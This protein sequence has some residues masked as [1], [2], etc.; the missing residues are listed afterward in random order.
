MVST[1][2]RIRV[3]GLEW[4]DRL[5]GVAMLWVVLNHIVEIVAGGNFAGAPTGDWP[6][7]SVRIAQWQIPVTGFGP[8]SW[9][10]TGARDVGWLADQAVSIFIILS[11]FGLTL[12]LVASHAGPRLDGRTFL[13]RRLKRIYPYWWGAHIL[14]LP[15]G[16]LFASGLSTGDWQ[17]YASFLGLRFLPDVFSYFASSWW[18][19]GVI[20]ELYLAFPVLWWILRA[21]GPLALLATTWGLG[22]LALA[23]GHAYLHGDLVE[24]WQRGICAVTRFPEFGFGMAL[25]LW[26]AQD[27]S[28]GA[29]TLRR[30]AVRVAA[31]GA[32]LA[33]FACSFTLPGM[34]VAPTVLGIAAIVLL[35][36]LAAWRATGRGPLEFVGR[37]SFTIYLT[38]QYL[39]QLFVGNNLSP[40]GTAIAIVCALLATAAATFVLE[41]G[42]A[43]VEALWERLTRRRGRAGAALVFASAALA[44]IALP[45]VTEL[46]LRHT[47]AR[48][49]AAPALRPDA[50]FGWR[51][52]PSQTI[53]LPGPADVAVLSNAEGFPG[54]TL[55]RSKRGNSVRI[56]VLGDAISSARVAR[57]NAWPELL[58]SDLGQL[59][60]P[61][62]VAN[63]AVSGYGPNQEAPVAR[64]FAARYRPDVVL[65]QV[66]PDDVQDVL[67]DTDTLRKKMGMADATDD[68]RSLL[69]L[70]R[71]H[72]LLDAKFIGPLRE[73]LHRPPS[74][75]AYSLGI[76]YVERGH[77]DWDGAAVGRSAERYREIARTARA[78]GAQTILVFVPA[79]AQVCAAG[80][81]AGFPRQ[82]ALADRSRYDLDLPNR[83]AR[84]IAAEAKLDLWDLSSDLRAKFPC[85]Y[86]PSA[87]YLRPEAAREIASL[88][89]PR[90]LSLLNADP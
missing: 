23:A 81:L 47:T 48:L 70:Q 87:P 53:A 61:A 45:I 30:P 69:E 11:G 8:L 24:M 44:I 20:I 39:I 46:A 19:V 33:G 3:S 29:A 34:I 60:R 66:Y 50:A 77:D 41:R 1:P 26:W 51:F 22:F 43:A 72:A 85:A 88:L 63:F 6:P 79:P 28:R 89:A 84:E 14:F 80:D 71:M 21:R 82:I 4:V 62:Q 31:A 40:A 18:Y 27:P 74:T 64:T 37:H 10:L 7:L 55:D 67:T 17:Y 52:L 49:A 35:Y 56:F 83:R 75:E 32:Y 16:Y 58:A 15:A 5:K 38:H 42:T 25:A 59:H 90:L 65:I 73:S 68:A 78:V 12:G 76:A 57:A 13:W 36:P 86:V 2:A 54:P 9:A